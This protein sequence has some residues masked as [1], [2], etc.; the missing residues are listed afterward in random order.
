MT[1]AGASRRWPRGSMP[2]NAQTKAD[3]KADKKAA[4][5]RKKRVQILSAHLVAMGLPADQ[6]EQYAISLVDAG[7]EEEEDI[8][9]LTAEELTGLGF[10]RGHVKKITRQS[11]AAADAGF[12]TSAL[13]GIS[14]E[15]ATAGEEHQAGG[16]AAAGAPGTMDQDVSPAQS[17]AAQDLSAHLISLGFPEE[18]AAE[19]AKQL[20]QHGCTTTQALHSMDDDQ[21][22]S[23]GLGKG[24]IKRVRRFAK[25][26]SE[27]VDVGARVAAQQQ[28]QQPQGAVA[29]SA[30]PQRPISAQAE[31]GATETGPQASV[32]DDDA[33]PEPETVAF[34]AAGV[35][36]D[37]SA[38]GAVTSESAAAAAVVEPI[39]RVQQ[40]G[41]GSVPGV[42]HQDDDPYAGS[43]PN[44][45]P[46]GAPAAAAA[47]DDDDD[48]ASVAVDQYAGAPTSVDPYAGAPVYAGAPAS[49]D[50]YAGAS[51][52]AI[53]IA[54]SAGPLEAVPPEAVPPPRQVVDLDRPVQFREAKKNEAVFT[55]AKSLMA[56]SWNK[57]DKFEFVK[58]ESVREIDNPRLTFR[59]EEYC[60]AC[61]HL[62]DQHNEQYFFHGSS[63]TAYVGIAEKGF[64][65]SFQTSAAGE[66]QRFG[67]GFYFA[68]HASKS[69]DYPLEEMKQRPE[70]EQSRSM[71]L[72]KVAK[73]RVFSTDTNMAHL[74]EPPTGFHSVHGKASED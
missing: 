62:P 65:K 2:Q 48:A 69:H 23:V 46:L 17:P 53:A 50:P 38:P 21:L 64:L 18:Q 47:A 58:V 60:A 3:K 37:S 36:L 5:L 25:R 19:F 35:R 71:L 63:E 68:L 29:D 43:E 52:P 13:G 54:N 49:V 72:C 27:A 15:A 10:K 31:Q 20:V 56:T 73:G 42:T 66:W 34:T 30:A 26:P 24:H 22:K 7:Y 59:Y 51:A 9:A 4:K 11:V 45:T 12:T 74:K 67:N 1:A 32:V 39:R 70:G 55:Q 40:H 8:G 41:D 61:S 14:Q 44:G 6:T 57:K 33:E 28:Q 16:G